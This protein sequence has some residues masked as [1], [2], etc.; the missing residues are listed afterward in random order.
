MTFFNYYYYYYF[1][2]TEQ[3][4][5][6]IFQKIKSKSEDLFMM[7]NYENIKMAQNF[8]M[9]KAERTNIKILKTIDHRFTIGVTASGNISNT[10]DFLR[11]VERRV[12]DKIVVKKV[13]KTPPSYI[14]QGL[15]SIFQFSLLEY[16][17]W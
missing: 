14:F 5:I 7:Y 15:Y 3:D 16:L 2:F 13:R 4:F 12:V 11:C 10:E 17:T 9:A 1:F 8:G 6:D